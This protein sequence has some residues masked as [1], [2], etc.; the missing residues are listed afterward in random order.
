MAPKRPLLDCADCPAV[1]VEGTE[2]SQF[3]VVAK[4]PTWMQHLLAEPANAAVMG[5]L[6]SDH[7][8]LGTREIYF[9]PGRVWLRAHPRRL[10]EAQL[11][12]WLGDLLAVAEAAE[13]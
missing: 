4:D 6:L 13:Q 7:E 2:L 3:L 9:Q 12:Q 8:T 5:R 10:T 11:R 1:D